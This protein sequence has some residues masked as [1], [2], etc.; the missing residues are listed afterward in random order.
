MCGLY[1][2][3]T[4]VLTKRKLE[5]RL[6]KEKDYVK[7]QGEGRHQGERPLKKPTLLTPWFQTSCF[8]N[9]GK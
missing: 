7:T 1:L 3:M 8:Q 2:N 6:T 9:C 5:Q 4:D